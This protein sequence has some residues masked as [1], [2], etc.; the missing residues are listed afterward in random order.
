MRIIQIMNHLGN[1]FQHTVVALDGNFSARNRV[2]ADVTLH[3]ET[4][5][6]TSNPLI[7]AARLRKLMNRRRPDIVLTYNWGAID[8]AVA[9]LLPPRIPTIHTEDGFGIE[10]AVQQKKRRVLMRRLVLPHVSSVIAPSQ[11]LLD[12]MR[13]QW[14]L[15]EKKIRYI[16]NGID[17]KVFSPAAAPSIRDE[18]LIGTAAQLRPEKRLDIL[19]RTVAQ[20][21]TRRNV[22]LHIAGDGPKREDLQLSSGFPPAS[23][24]WGTSKM[25]RSFIAP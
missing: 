11:V 23:G 5:K 16:P 4:C 3:Q 12:M 10:E 24:S 22:S 6:R 18:V 9:A 19:L 2:S 14:R 25:W 21:A 8:G 7:L 1:R 15:P 17:S 13:G 20:I